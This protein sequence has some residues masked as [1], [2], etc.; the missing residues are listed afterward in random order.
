VSGCIGFV[1]EPGP[2]LFVTYDRSPSPAK[3]MFTSSD[4][5]WPLPRGKP[6]TSAFTLP[7]V[8]ANGP[9]PATAVTSRERRTG[10][11]PLGAV[12]SSEHSRSH[13]PRTKSLHPPGRTGTAR[14]LAATVVRAGI[15]SS[16]RGSGHLANQAVRTP[17]P[18]C[19][20]RWAYWRVCRQPRG[21]SRGSR[22][23]ARRARQTHMGGAGQDRHGPRPRLSEPIRDH[24]R[25]S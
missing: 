20:A 11:R 17:G 23:L 1:R 16:R 15:I 12:R 18:P 8:G 4:R 10:P 5:T 13:F 22:S 14:G 24:W 21:D 9:Q 3:S 7:L 19:Q 2:R 6:L 25:T